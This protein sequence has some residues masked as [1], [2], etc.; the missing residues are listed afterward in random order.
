MAVH[1]RPNIIINDISFYLDAMNLKSLKFE[2]R[3]YDYGIW[4]NGQTGS[5]GDFTQYSS[6]NA[7]VLAADPWGNIITVWKSYSV[8][9]STS[10]GGIYMNYKSID[11]TKMHRM[12]WW[13]K[14]VTNSTSTYCRYYAGLNGSP[15]AVRN[16]SNGSLNSNPYFYN[17]SNI[18]SELQLP[19]NTWVLVVGHVWPFN[20]GTGS[21]H[22][23]SGRYTI[24]GGKL[25]NISADYVFDEL[26]TSVR[27]RTLAIYSASNQQN[28][29]DVLHYTA[30][31]RLDVCDGTEPSIDDLLNNRT[32]QM[33]DLSNNF[34]SSIMINGPI[35]DVDSI[36]FSGPNRTSPQY[37]ENIDNKWTQVF[38]NSN[39]FTISVWIYPVISEIYNQ[40]IISQ[41]HGKAISLILM[42]NGRITLELGTTDTYEGTNTIFESNKWYNVTVTYINDT[43]NS[44][45]IYYVN[46]IFD[47]QENNKWNGGI[48]VDNMIKIGYQSEDY[49]I[50]PIDYC[51]KIGVVRIYNREL[52]SDEILQNYE[53]VK[54][55]YLLI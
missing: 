45:C 7:R 13:E 33:Y 44:Y 23:D 40:T 52:S 5:I 6:N 19:V 11:N 34:S 39:N 26:T 54:N 29:N 16:R 41:V 50:N 55:R 30:Y 38:N 35:F 27:S 46:G 18:P 21:I 4:Q 32:D 3:L 2:N 9:N 31:P 14:R 42:T 17:T 20:S 48:I 10:G 12:S 53:S 24:N 8:L 51:G 28:T 36:K 25:G 37:I 15:T 43:T 47:K 22:D 49:G 1:I